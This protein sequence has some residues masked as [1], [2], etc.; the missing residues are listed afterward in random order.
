MNMR[1]SINT[2]TYLQT[3]GYTSWNQFFILK[4]IAI[5]GFWISDTEGLPWSSKWWM[6]RFWK[7]MNIGNRDKSSWKKNDLKLL[8]SVYVLVSP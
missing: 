3:E 8:F 5:I 6:G 7:D 2:E 4:Q 1:Y